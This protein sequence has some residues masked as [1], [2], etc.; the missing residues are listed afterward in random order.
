ML[1]SGIHHAHNGFPPNLCPRGFGGQARGNDRKRGE[2]SDGEWG[3]LRPHELRAQSVWE[4]RKEPFIVI[5]AANPK[6][7]HSIVLQDTDGAI[8][9]SYPNRPNIFLGIDALKT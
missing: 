4:L 2:E 6:P 9:T 5:V 3:V 8:T 7:R 1:L